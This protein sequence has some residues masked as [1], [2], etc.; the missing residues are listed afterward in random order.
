MLAWQYLT[1]ADQR[2]KLAKRV[3]LLYGNNSRLHLFA[4]THVDKLLF[5]L[6]LLNLRS[7]YL[8]LR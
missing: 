3:L 6:E 8:I 7:K 1:T 4:L 5:A 2:I